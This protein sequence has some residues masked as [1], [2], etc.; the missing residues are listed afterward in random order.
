MDGI[1]WHED[2]GVWFP[3]YDHKPKKCLARVRSGLRH[4]DH[5]IK[6]ARAARACIQAGGHAGLWPQRLAGF[7]STVYTFE[8]EKALFECMKRNV[9]QQN[10][11]MSDKALGPYA[12][13]AR[14]KAHC[15][16]GSWRI[17]DAGKHEVD[18]I[19]IDSLNLPACDAIFLDIEGFEI[20][21]LSGGYETIM[22]YQ[23]VLH[24]EVLGGKREATDAF[25]RTI[26]Y[27]PVHEIGNDVVYQR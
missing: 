9:V 7:F 11:I 3:S 5:A 13:R 6:I 25:M 27:K 20:R 26:D 22:K 15:S 24:V 14:F 4:S 1:E 2:Y 18:M 17:D 21:A 16:A 10:V 8:P 19:T 23:P 12:G